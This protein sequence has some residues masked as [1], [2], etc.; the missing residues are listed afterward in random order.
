MRNVTLMDVF[1]HPIAQKYLTRSG[2]A[3]AVACAYH[4]YRL[5]VNFHEI[6]RF[7]TYQTEGKLRSTSYVAG[8]LLDLL[9]TDFENGRVYDIKEFL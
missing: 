8:I 2:V 5:A 4:A 6:E 3:H 1:T 9:E 7:K